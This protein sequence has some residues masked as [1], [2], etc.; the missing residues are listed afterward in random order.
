[1]C[2]GLITELAQLS[3]GTCSAAAGKMSDASTDCF[4]EM[5]PQRSS[6]DLRAAEEAQHTLGKGNELVAD[7]L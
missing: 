7:R 2:K 3:T 6:S 4:L 1:M 5:I